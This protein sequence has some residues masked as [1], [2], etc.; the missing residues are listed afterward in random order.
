MNICINCNSEIEEEDG[1]WR[2][3]DAA[4]AALG[5]GAKYWTYCFNEP[6]DYTQHEPDPFILIVEKAWREL[7]SGQ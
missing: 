7:N 3:T 2:R 1:I 5:N 4:L 6:Q